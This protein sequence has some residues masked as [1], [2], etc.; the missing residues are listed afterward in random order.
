M[1]GLSRAGHIC[2]CSTWLQITSIV[3]TFRIKEIY[4]C[5]ESSFQINQS[6]VERQ[7]L[8]MWPNYCAWDKCRCI[9]KQ[10]LFSFITHEWE[11]SWLKSILQ[12]IL[13][14]FT[15]TL[16]GK[17][18][19][20]EYVHVVQCCTEK[21]ALRIDYIHIW[22]HYFNDCV[23]ELHAPFGKV[24]TL[25]VPSVTKGEEEAFYPCPP[26]R[27]AANCLS[28]I[29]ENWCCL[30]HHPLGLT[31]CTAADMHPRVYYSCLASQCSCIEKKFWTLNMIARLITSHTLWILYYHVP[32]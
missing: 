26:P 4:P 21:Q 18:V 15:C 10:G 6:K 19:Q 9:Q 11:I 14:M 31:L 7:Q 27:L 30:Y 29:V 28:F 22:L 12:Y 32:N 17:P 23:K 24:I 25:T 3:A 16:T 8:S 13:C 2:Q 5:I 20:Y 1:G